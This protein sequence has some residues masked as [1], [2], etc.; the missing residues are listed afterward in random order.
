MEVSGQLHAPAGLH[1]RKSPW[2]PF[3]R[4]LGGP[5]SQ[6]GRG[7]DE[8]ISPPVLGLESPINQPIVQRYTNDLSPLVLFI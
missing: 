8:K 6:S 1:Q 3:D 5:K 2:Y 7:G 4:R